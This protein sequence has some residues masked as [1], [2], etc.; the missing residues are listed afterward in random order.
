MMVAELKE[1]SPMDSVLKNVWA[2]YRVWAA[3]ARAEK[4]RLTSWRWYVLIFSISG[5]ILGTLCHQSRGWVEGNAGDQL[6][7]ALGVLSAIALGLAVFFT[8]EILNPEQERRWVRSRSAAEALKAEAYLLIAQVSNYDSLDPNQAFDRVEKIE[9]AVEDIQAEHIDARQKEEG[10]PDS[11]ITVEEY[12]EIRVK[13]QVN[14]FYIPR[15]KEHAVIIKRARTISLSLGVLAIVLGGLG[16][17]APTAGRTAGWVAVISTITAAI[18][19]YLYAN[20][21]QYLVIS[22][23]ATARRLESLI[24]RWRASGKTDADTADRDQFIIKCEEAISVE[25]NGWMAEWIKGNKMD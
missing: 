16:A 15:A 24:A 1:K 8:R 2:Q 22:Y 10:L 9:K 20:R 7:C 18:A 13:D 3:T 12:I 5:A 21:Y 11:P 14:N 6:Q 25:N 17:F 4:A 23:E 19:A